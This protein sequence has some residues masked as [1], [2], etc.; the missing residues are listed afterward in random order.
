M[1]TL[2]DYITETE[3]LLRDN[4]NKVYSPIDLTRWVNEGIAI[5][6]LDLGLNRMKYG[7]SLSVGVYQ[8][9]FSQVLAGT[10]MTGKV[11]TQ[12]IDVISIVVVPLGLA[13][14]QPRYPLGRWPYSMLAP[15][16]A[17]TSPTLPAKYAMYGPD[18]IIVGPPPAVGYPCEI[19]FFGYT[20]PLVNPTDVDPLPFP[21]TSP[22]KYYAAHMAKLQNQRFDE[23]EKYYSTNPQ[24]PGLYQHSLAK[25][26]ARGRPMAVANPW[27]DM[28]R[29]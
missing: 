27:S 12:P 3:S 4:S 28:P 20:P 10:L 1:A 23:A 5:R 9:T 14:S 25:C 8:Y 17:R 21:W 29:R 15:L 7:F 16:L 11:A 2:Q 6:D 26:R 24:T 19:D 13:T 18:T 22:V